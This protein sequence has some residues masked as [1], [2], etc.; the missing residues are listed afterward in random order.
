[1]FNKSFTIVLINDISAAALL[2][3]VIIIPSVF[4]NIF[5]LD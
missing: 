4:I 2:A 3:G 1:M 5:N